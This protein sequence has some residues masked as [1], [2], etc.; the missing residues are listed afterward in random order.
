MAYILWQ[1]SGEKAHA[2]AVLVVIRDQAPFDGICDC[3]PALVVLVVHTPGIDLAMFINN[4]QSVFQHGK[5]GVGGLIAIQRPGHGIRQPDG[6]VV[7]AVGQEGIEA[8]MEPSIIAAFHPAGQVQRGRG[9][10]ILCGFRW[11]RLA[12]LAEPAKCHRTTFQPESGGGHLLGQ[13]SISISAAVQQGGD[14][15]RCLVGVKR[16][17]LDLL[18]RILVK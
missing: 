7:A 9:G 3:L 16:N 11:K 2:Q 1:A 13:R 4:E 12:L 18:D 10:R 8:D 5:P 15:P 14:P 17:G 6:C